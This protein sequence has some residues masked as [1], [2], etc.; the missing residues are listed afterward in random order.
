M[1]KR[2]WKYWQK[3]KAKL[4]ESEHGQSL[5]E[6]VIIMPL[7]LLLF[8][9]VFDVGRSLHAYVV[10]L[11]ASREAAMLGA[12]AEVDTNTLHNHAL[13]ELLRGGLVPGQAEVIVEY[14]QRGYPPEDHIIVQVNY[15]LPLM[16]AVLPISNINLRTKTEMLTFW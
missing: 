11:N 7:L 14:Q 4:I 3:E 9:G 16:L 2:V 10:M 5:V 13:A 1:A 6:F 8:A 12:A 15:N